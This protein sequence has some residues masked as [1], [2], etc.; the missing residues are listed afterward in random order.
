M[1]Q[2]EINNSKF[3]FSE[4]EKI[5]AVA[6]RAGINIPTLCYSQETECGGKCMVCAVKDLETDSFLPACTTLCHE[7]MRLDSDSHEVQEF[8][9]QA[10]ELLLSE[11]RG[12]CEAPCRI[13]CPQFLDIPAF[14]MELATN[15]TDFHFNHQICIECGGRCEKACRR[16]RFDTP[17]KIRSLLE[18]SGTDDREIGKIS[19]LPGRYRHVFGKLD[20]ALIIKMYP[21]AE[22]SPDHNNYTP[23]QSEARRCLQCACS[24]ADLCS[25]RDLATALAAQ[26]HRYK[27]D[28]LPDPVL[29]I[30]GTIIFNSGKC[31]KCERC[32][33]LGRRLKPGSGPVTTGRGS[34][35]LIAPP[36]GIDFSAAFAGFEARF[37]LECPTG[38]LS[39]PGSKRKKK[40]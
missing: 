10:V 32:V 15:R 13:V 25:L 38:A 6:A 39:E 23:E 27:A 17:L 4:G 31:I 29:L 3:T 26:Q 8:R 22:S 9:Q 1:K 34:N 28:S 11:H 36:L 20:Q 35:S 5:L 30:S 40:I 14:M 7:S 12:D 18:K 2:I 24:A 21:A 19:A 33:E 37:I 16:G